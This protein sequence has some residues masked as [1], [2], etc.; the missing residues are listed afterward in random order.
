MTVVSGIEPTEISVN[1][2]DISHLFKN[3]IPT[4]QDTRCGYI[5]KMNSLL[6]FF[7]L[8]VFILITIQNAQIYFV[9]RLHNCLIIRK[10]VEKA[11]RALKPDV[12]PGHYHDCNLK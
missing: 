11:N 2:F 5:M 6:C 4:K 1:K 7:K 8:S 10:Y 12:L 9:G 3:L